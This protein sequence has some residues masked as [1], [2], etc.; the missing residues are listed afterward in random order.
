MDELMVGKTDAGAEQEGDCAEEIR[1][2]CPVV[3]TH[4]PD[5]LV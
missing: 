3:A 4:L 1:L 5:V 2:G